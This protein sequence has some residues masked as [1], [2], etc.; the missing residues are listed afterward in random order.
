[1]KWITCLGSENIYSA[2]CVLIGKLTG[3]FPTVYTQQTKQETWTLVFRFAHHPK[4]SAFCEVASLI[5][6][7]WLFE[8]IAHGNNKYLK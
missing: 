5:L 8:E 2:R 6:C 7:P 3:R 4:E 1:M